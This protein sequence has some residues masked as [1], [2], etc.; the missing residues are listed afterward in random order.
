MTEEVSSAKSQKISLD[1][2]G[3]S[4]ASCAGGIEAT[5]AQTQGVLQSRVNLA[6][7]KAV[8]EYDP[9]KINPPQM[10]KLIKEMGYSVVVL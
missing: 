4:C 9:Q 7:F 3:M 5:L 8:I 2:S 10:A 6:S 1:I